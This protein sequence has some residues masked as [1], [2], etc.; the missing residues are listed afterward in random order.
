MLKSLPFETAPADRRCRLADAM[1]TGDADV[2]ARNRKRHDHSHSFPLLAK[3]LTISPLASKMSLHAWRRIK[4]GGSPARKPRASLRHRRLILP[5]SQMTPSE[6]N[7]NH[8]EPNASV[9]TVDKSDI[10]KRTKSTVPPAPCAKSP[11]ARNPPL[12][13]RP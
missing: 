1:P 10:S 7:R 13:H 12:W 9:Q 11:M 3:I 6:A 8:K 4:T 2:D 5:C